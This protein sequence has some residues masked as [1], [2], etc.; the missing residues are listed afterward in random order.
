MRI[1]RVLALGCTALVLVAGVDVLARFQWNAPAFEEACYRFVA[2]EGTPSVPAIPM[3]LRALAV[4]QR[5]SAVEALGARVRA[6]YDSEAFQRLWIERHGGSF[7]EPGQDQREAEKAAERKQAEAMAD[8]NLAD[9]ERMIPMMPPGMQAKVRADLAKAQA[10]RD[11]A[12]AKA[13]ASR[14]EGAAAG[15]PPVPDPKVAL[16]KALTRFLQVSDGVDYNAP[17]L[18]RERRAYFSDPAL[19]ANPEIWKACF[20]A[21]KDATEAARGYA[22]TWLNELK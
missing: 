17:L 11:R 10:K 3:P 18:H 16:K 12:Q 20:R 6:Y 19:E 15:R 7:R 21:G 5:R 22:R 13:A 4:G 14:G 2:S 9:M 1:P 8:K